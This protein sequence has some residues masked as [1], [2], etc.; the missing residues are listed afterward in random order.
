M[1]SSSAQTYNCVI[2]LS[3]W[4][5]NRTTKCKNSCS[6]I[7]YNLSQL[8]KLQIQFFLQPLKTRNQNSNNNHSLWYFFLKFP[9]LEENKEQN[10]REALKGKIKVKKS[11]GN[12]VCIFL[13]RQ[14]RCN[15]S[16]IDLMTTKIYVWL[17]PKI[18]PDNQLTRATFHPGKNII[19]DNAD[20]RNDGMREINRFFHV[21]FALNGEEEVYRTWWAREKKKGR[22]LNRNYLILRET[23]LV[24]T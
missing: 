20:K 21:F 3:S 23:N 24:L 16:G 10:V 8:D 13:L 9:L 22:T 7:N 18:G 19:V 17:I 2:L 4:S 5:M 15:A 12:S 14:Q 1:L 6:P 11:Q